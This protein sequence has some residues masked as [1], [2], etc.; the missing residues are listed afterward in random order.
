M[1]GASSMR[2]RA[3]RRRLAP[4]GLLALAP[5]LLVLACAGCGGGSKGGST[6]GASRHPTTTRTTPAPSPAV[7]A[8]GRTIFVKHCSMCHT[9][10]GKVA[11]PTFIES[12]IPNLDEVKPK[13]VYVDARVLGGGFDMPSL[14][15]QL[16]PR[17]IA[18]VVA[19]VAS[20]SGRNIGANEGTGDLTLGETVFEHNCQRCHTIANHRSNGKPTYPGTDFTFVRPSEKMIL[21]RIR[22]GIKEE[23]PSFRKALSDAEMRAVA[24]YVSS[25]AGR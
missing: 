4:S 1:D 12:P 16:K 13:A 3:A 23:M 5:V 22:K 18:A 11:H 14:Q 17:Q 6:G 20:V 24:A 7:M 21:A 2:D 9:L 10:A 19:Y 8:A 25:A 15:G